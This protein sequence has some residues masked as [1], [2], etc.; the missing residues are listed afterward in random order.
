MLDVVSVVE[1]RSRCK[2]I[3]NDSWFL[4]HA[5]S[6]RAGNTRQRP[7]R[8]TGKIHKQEETWNRVQQDI[9]TVRARR[10]VSRAIGRREAQA[11]LMSAVMSQ[12]PVPPDGLRKAKQHAEKNGVR[13]IP[14]ARSKERQMDEIVRDG[15]GV[16][17]QADGD[18]RY[19]RDQE[20]RHR[21]EKG[22]PDQNGVPS[23]VAEQ[24]ARNGVCCDGFHAVPV[25]YS[26]TTFSAQPS[27]GQ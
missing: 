8:I 5:R 13:A 23:R 17:P 24:S 25:F 27:A 1:E 18:D 12:M 16:P 26:F 4:R 21:M 3:H 9:P 20:H 22:Q 19:R 10:Q 7:E 15:V 11:A 2:G 6:I 14:S